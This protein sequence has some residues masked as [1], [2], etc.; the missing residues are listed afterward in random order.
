ML[1]VV[2]AALATVAGLQ[3]TITYPLLRGE[4]IGDC[5]ENGAQAAVPCRLRRQWSAGALQSRMTGDEAVWRD[6][7]EVTF[8]RKTPDGAVTL[9]VAA[10]VLPMGWVPDS[11]LWVVTIR[12]PDAPRAALTYQFYSMQG[13]AGKPTVWRA[14]TRAATMRSA[15]LHG[16]L[17]RD[18]LTDARTGQRR[19]L[20]SYVPP[21]PAS[22]DDLHVVYLADGESVSE[23]APGI[24]TLVAAGA[25][26]PVVLVGIASSATQRNLEYVRGVSPDSAP[27]LAHERFVMD[28]VMRWAQATLHASARRDRRMIL[29]MSSGGAFAV[30]LALRHPDRFGAAIALSP[31]G[32]APAVATSTGAWPLFVLTAGTL[33][34]PLLAQARVARQRLEGA[35]APVHFDLLV[36]GHDE[37][38][39]FEDVPRLVAYAINAGSSIR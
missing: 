1:A 39:W 21:G 14:D 5:A 23:I 34:P 16:H 33:E 25:I 27:Y 11:E 17:R 10:M 31:A 4:M 12:I 2:L 29:G 35:G 13:A 30:S 22:Q 15:A 8:A 7:D 18:T 28:D 24:D 32:A 19:A 36:S 37:R 9:H 38:V 6:G 20:L 26:P 3:D